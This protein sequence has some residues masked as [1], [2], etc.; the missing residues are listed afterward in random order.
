[1][2]L[3]CLGSRACLGLSGDARDMFASCSV[4]SRVDTTFRAKVFS[5]RACFRASFAEL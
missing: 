5:F 3:A 4:L 1:M 2:G